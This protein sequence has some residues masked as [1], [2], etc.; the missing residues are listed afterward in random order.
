MSQLRLCKMKDVYTSEQIVE[1]IRRFVGAANV[2]REDT[3]REALSEIKKEADN[4][5]YDESEFLNKIA[6]FIESKIC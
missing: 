4:G 3:L 1:N 5:Y 2:C 6:E